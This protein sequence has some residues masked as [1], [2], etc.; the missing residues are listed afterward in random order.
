MAYKIIE[1]A[2]GL[3]EKQVVVKLAARYYIC[4]KFTNPPNTNSVRTP[5]LGNRAARK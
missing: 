1:M 5:L 2:G 3:P 4:G